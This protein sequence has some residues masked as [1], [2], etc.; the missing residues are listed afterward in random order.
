MASAT[1]ATLDAKA[2]VGATVTPTMW[3]TRFTDYVH[4]R[5]ECIVAD[6]SE[7]CLVRPTMVVEQ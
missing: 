2:V 1:E 5:R 3:H 7:N 6:R 4:R